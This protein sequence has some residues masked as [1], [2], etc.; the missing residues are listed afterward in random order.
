MLRHGF[1]A[2]CF[3]DFI[4]VQLRVILHLA[5]ELGDFL[6]TKVLTVIALAQTVILLFLFSKTVAI[7]DELNATGLARHNATA[8]DRSY[9][10]PTQARASQTQYDLTATQFRTIVQEELQV[11]LGS[12]P[13]PDA[14]NIMAAAS[15][16][17][18]EAERQY[19]LEQ[20]EQKIEY[21][22]SVGSISD[23]DMQKLQM[24][25]ATLDEAGR[26]KML[27]TLTRALNSGR[28]EGRF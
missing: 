15:T 8:G 13:A 21:F 3:F 28:L 1:P 9:D 11:F 16:P 25:I 23:T 10:P 7:E 14:Q 20:V 5:L 26:K 2:R 12:V 24:D 18:D 6:Q 19:Q 27:R 4:T 22:E 17:V